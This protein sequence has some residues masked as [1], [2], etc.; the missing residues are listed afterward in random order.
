[1]VTDRRSLFYEPYDQLMRQTLLAWQMVERHEFA[2]TDWVHVQVI[3]AGNTALR[4]RGGAPPE[5]AGHGLADVWR[6]V[7]RDPGRY[8]LLSPTEV[9][10]GVKRIPRWSAWSTWLTRRYLT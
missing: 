4:G 1:M 10:A 9:V 5:L 3:P 8:Q 7:L 6:A 2:A